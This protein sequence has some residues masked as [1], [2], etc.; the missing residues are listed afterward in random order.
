MATRRDFLATSAALGCSAAAA[1]FVTPVVLAAAPGKARLVVIIL[2]GGLD[3]LDT[4]APVGDPGFAELGRSRAEGAGDLGG[5]FALHPALAP[6]LPLW[7]AGELGFAHAVATPYRDKRSHFDGQ[8]LLENGGGRSDGMMTKAEDGW[9]NRFL[10]QIGGDDPEV[11][12]S[13]GREQMRLMTGAAAHSSWSPEAAMALSPQGELLLEYIYRR[14]PLFAEAA[15][16]AMRLSADVGG[17][18]MSPGKAA[19]AEALAHFAAGRLA[20]ETR[21]AAFSLTGFDTH[22]NQKAVLS[23]SLGELATAITTLKTEL[24]SVWDSTAVVA[25]TEF[26]RTARLNG[27]GGTDHGTGGV[28]FM[29]GGAIKGGRILGRWPGLSEADLYQR[30]DLLPTDDLR[31]YMGWLLRDLFGAQASAIERA[32]FPGLDMA[33]NPGL[34]L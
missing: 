3:G 33:Q 24:G 7:Q 32:V 25:M 6:L 23:R 8:D 19:R 20:A 17:A 21:I 11:A 1:P 15:A 28:M 26:G 34:L 31:R 2:R 16:R 29:A 4:V 30:R 5:Y 12:F 22:R 9:L 27:S 14:D 18:S 10:S 13:V